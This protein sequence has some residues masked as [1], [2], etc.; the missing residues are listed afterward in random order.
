M[1][2]LFSLFLPLFFP[3]ILSSSILA[4]SPSNKNLEVELQ[5]ANRKLAEM[6]RD[7]EEIKK[8][9]QNIELE[10]QNLNRE[11]LEHNSLYFADETQIQGFS[12]P[13]ADHQVYTSHN[14]FEIISFVT[15]TNGLGERSAFVVV[16]NNGAPA[17]LLREY[18]VATFADNERVI[19]QRLSKYDRIFQ[20][21]VTTLMVYFGYNDTPIANVSTK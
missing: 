10:L 4:Q 5:E 12:S 8:R 14:D 15:M 11:A 1:K 18:F 2:R 20:G 16:K 13:F 9:L 17:Q 7:S 3:L 6:E 19:S 21:E